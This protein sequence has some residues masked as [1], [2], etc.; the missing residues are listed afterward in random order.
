MSLTELRECGLRLYRLLRKLHNSLEGD[1]AVL[2]NKFIKNEFK[3]HHYPTMPNFTADHYIIFMKEWT[4]YLVTMSQRET[5][6]FG[7]PM[8]PETFNLLTSKQKESLRLLKIDIYERHNKK[9]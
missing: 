5:R 7:K 3:Q 2:G 8:H 9:E 4:D 1:F 6:M